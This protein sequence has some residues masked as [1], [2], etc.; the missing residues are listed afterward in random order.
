MFVYIW[1]S[2][3]GID[4]YPSTHRT[5][6]ACDWSLQLMLSPREVHQLEVEMDRKR[7]KKEYLQVPHTARCCGLEKA[8]SGTKLVGWGQEA[9]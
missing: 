4:Q 1:G 2:R 9:R 6:L 3:E 7:K 8:E 5:A